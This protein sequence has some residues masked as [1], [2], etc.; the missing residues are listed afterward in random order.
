MKLKARDSKYPVT[1]QCK[2]RVL[3][4]VICR[5]KVSHCSSQIDAVGFIW[6][7]GLSVF[8]FEYAFAFSCLHEFIMRQTGMQY[9]GRPL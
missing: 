4:V 8:E 9:K 7:F 3:A 1:L 2:A 6:G 5:V